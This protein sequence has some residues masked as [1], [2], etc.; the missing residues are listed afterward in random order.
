VAHYHRRAGLLAPH[1]ASG[2]AVVADVL[3]GIRRSRETPPGCK[4]AADADIVIRLLWSIEDE[5]LAA[6]RDRATLAFGMATAA[7][8]SELVALDMDDLEWEPRGVRV[9]IRRSKTDQEGEGQVV[10]VPEGRRLHPVAHLRAWLAA[11]GIGH[12][13][14]FRPLWKGGRRVWDARL[15]DHAVARIVQARAEA[16]GLDPARYAGHSLR[17]GLASGANLA[18]L[19]RQT[20]HR[21]TQVALAYLRPA[22]LWG[23][24]VTQKVFGAD[25]DGES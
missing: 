16:A 20:R 7:R 23:N 17:A 2:G 22:D 24:T 15:S 1:R 6:M 25:K 12:G 13:P 11:A 18:D 14:V 21:S 9:T 8:R 4:T 3:A 19:M 5:G 10:A